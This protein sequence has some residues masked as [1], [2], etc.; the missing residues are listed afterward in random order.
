MSSSVLRSVLSGL[1]LVV[2]ACGGARTPPATSPA[3]SSGE[4][5]VAAPADLSPNVLRDRRAEPGVRAPAKPLAIGK[6]G[7]VKCG[8]LVK[9]AADAE[10]TDLLAGRLRLRP[11]PGA[12]VP[13]PLPDAPALE[14]ESR[15]IVDASSK[16]DG[17][18]SLAIVARETFQLDP[19]LY[20]P[21]ADAPTKPATLD[22]EAPKFLKATF[23][24]DEPLEVV[25]VE[26][27]TDAKVR[28]YAARPPRPNAPP[29]KDTALV[30]ALLVAQP[31][32]TLESIGFYVRGE[33]VRN[34]TGADLVGC[35]RLA[36]R[37]AS[38]LTPGPRQLERS[39]GRR[40]VADV[41]PAGELEVTVPAD[42][43]SVPAGTGARIYKLRPISL[44]AGSISVSIAEGGGSSV[45]GDADA[46]AAGTLLGRPTEWRGK[47]SPKGGFFFASEPLDPPD[48]AKK[49]AVLVK[50]TRQA[51]ALDEMRKVAETLTIVKPGS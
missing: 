15:V 25:P 5:E 26:I 46:T 47:T 17:K 21:E 42:Y 16:K 14:E 40:K 20:E 39:A 9:P 44:Y 43:V 3:A 50:A 10:P 32:G 6:A 34:A 45:P 29:G 30:L 28:A 23:P 19:D 41:P 12:K 24:S 22:V 7:A 36:E 18:I 51:K 35:T 11:P 8:A 13:A 27:G 31:D 49:A 48:G 37:I 1:A 33:T 2:G 38:T 4:R